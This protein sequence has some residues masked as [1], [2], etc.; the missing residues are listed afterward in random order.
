MSLEMIDAFSD[1]SQSNA[2]KIKKP[3]AKKA[4]SSPY[5]PQSCDKD[6]S[7]RESPRKN[8]DDKPSSYSE[9][10]KTPNKKEKQRQRWI[11]RDE[12]A[13]GSPVDHHMLADFDFEKNLAL[14]NKKAFYEELNASKPDL[15]KQ[16]DKKGGKYRW[17]ENVLSSKPA[18]SR[19]LMVPY[20]DSIEYVT[21][22]GLVVPS[23]TTELRR[24]VFQVAEGCGLTF[25]RQSEIIGRACTEMAL[26][27]LGGAH[28][29]N[30]QNQHQC[31]HVIVMCCSSR[32]G[33]QGINT[34]RQLA[35]HGVRTTVYLQDAGTSA[36]TIEMNQE[37]E[38]YRLTCNNLAVNLH[39]MYGY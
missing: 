16:T 12:A 20:T 1:P 8:F 15:V 28:R 5:E 7:V 24:Q 25:Q 27:L 35:S 4:S 37:L 33:A 2:T 34:A 31:P 18:A 9:I 39:G 14:F 36:L 19:Q 11:S 3:V 29:L 23:L 13:F 30:P 17:D 21:D 32:T 22:T 10:T 6:L 26:M 38:L